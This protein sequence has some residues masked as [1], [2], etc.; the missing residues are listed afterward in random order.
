MAIFPSAY[1]VDTVDTLLARLD[2]LEPQTK[3]L[4]GKMN[5]PQMVAH[6]CVS[7]DMAYGIINDKP[8]FPINLIMRWI[9]KPMVVGPKPYPKNGKTAPVFKIVDE[10]DFML[11]K[12]RLIHNIKQVLK[13]GEQAFEGRPSPS[14]GPLT[15]SEW[16]ILF[17]KHLDHHFKQ[18]GI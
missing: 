10:R 2:K 8:G 11:E 9:I 16:S 5:A 6:V 3:A 15:A 12:D 17:Y 14:F 4:W 18:F 7:Y 1:S 13:D